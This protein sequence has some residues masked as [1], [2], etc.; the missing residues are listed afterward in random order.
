VAAAL[1]TTNADVRASPVYPPPVAIHMPQ[2][3]AHAASRVLC[4]SL[5]AAVVFRQVLGEPEEMA[6]SLAS[7]P[8]S[9]VPCALPWLA[10]TAAICCACL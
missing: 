1:A 6:A 10:R 4:Q 9:P 8:G 2:E 7:L 5:A 3:P